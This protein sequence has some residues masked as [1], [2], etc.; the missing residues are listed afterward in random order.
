MEIKYVNGKALFQPTFFWI[1]NLGGGG[2]DKYRETVYLDLYDGIPTLY[3]YYYLK[4]PA[5]ATKWINNINNYNNFGEFL[6]YTRESMINE[7]H[8]I[9]K[10]H[11][12][13]K[14][15]YENNI[16]LLDSGARNIL[17]DII[18]GK[19][20]NC[21][22]IEKSMIQ[23]MFE[24]YDFADKFKFDFIIGYDL[25]GKYTFKDNE[26][27]DNKLIDIVNKIDS[28]KLNNILLEETIKY[29]KKKNNYY[30]KIYATVHGTTPKEYEESIKFIVNCE[31]KY[32]FS[33]YGYALGGIASSKNIDKSWFKNLSNNKIS[34][35]YLV[36]MALKIVKKYSGLKP[37]HV[38]GG[39]NK[40]NI[41]S[42]VL[43]GATS[44]DCQTP[45]RRSYDGSK[46]SS[47]EVFNKNSN[48]SFSKYLPALIT[49][50]H[51]L[52]NE[53][54]PFDYIKLNI[55]PDEIKLC[56]CPACKEI[57]NIIQ[58]KELYSRKDESDEYY[59]YARQIMNSHAIWQHFF[60]TMI[61][62]D[63]KDYNDLIN[64]YPL[65]F[66]VALKDLFE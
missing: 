39:G 10:I 31:K 55:L 46:D 57:K 6:K 1:S 16:Y 35:E 36:T 29:I 63:C 27:K 3:N 19:I 5:F 22:T 41:P 64:K 12:P 58:L 21:G 52:K 65:D 53:S 51:Y 28:K 54:I 30:P 9:C 48:I 17:N 2:S 11:N 8:Y 56:D 20:V 38:L 18:R 23:Q 43:N 47:K 14:Y 37:I 50:N 26:K 45:G 40:D 7:E 66:F 33:F 59:Y 44:F 49:S 60:L 32:D 42:L 25:G 61:V 15:D 13:G 62:S 34:N 24:Y 4:Y